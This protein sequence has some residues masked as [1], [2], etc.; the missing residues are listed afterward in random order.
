MHRMPRSRKI[1]TS[2]TET[3]PGLDYAVDRRMMTWGSGKNVEDAVGEMKD[4]AAEHDYDAI[5]CI[6]LESVADVSSSI[7]G[8]VETSIFWIAYGTAIAFKP[9][10][11]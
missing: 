2:T 1:R 6:R 9:P 10:Y 4:W 8:I 7:T 11:P 3:I 5:V